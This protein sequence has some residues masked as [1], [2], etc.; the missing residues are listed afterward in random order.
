LRA[1]SNYL[2]NQNKENEQDVRMI[3]IRDREL[4][5]AG[6]DTSRTNKNTRKLFYKSSSP[7]SFHRASDA[8]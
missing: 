3:R 6:K 5:D 8:S 7:C 2:K 1:V 4:Q